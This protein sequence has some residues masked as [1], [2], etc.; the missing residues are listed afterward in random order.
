MSLSQTINKAVESAIQTYIAR[1]SKQ[2]NLDENELKN[3]WSGN[4]GSTA[5]PEPKE[6]SE[7]KGKSEL[8]NLNKQ[9]LIKLCKDKG[10]KSTGTKADMIQRLTNGEAPPPA[11]KQQTAPSGP[12]V[13]Q[14]ITS[15]IPNVSIR[16]N[17]HGN[18]EHSDTGLIFNNKTKKVIGKQN[19]NGTVDNLTS[20]D[21]ETCKQYKFQYELPENLDGKS[22]LANVAVEELD[23]TSGDDVLLDDEEEEFIGDEEGE[24][25]DDQEYFEED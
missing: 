6:K 23:E 24:E 16:R 17:N 15:V 3:I 7:P 19:D 4:P 5:K 20:E 8:D 21:I 9:E 18:F 1:I 22:S 10:F 12:P 14:K 2:Y 13:I 25:D 11:K